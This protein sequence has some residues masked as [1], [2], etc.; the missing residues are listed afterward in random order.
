M[1]QTLLGIL[2][3]F[4]DTPPPYAAVYDL[5]GDGFITILDLLQ[6]LSL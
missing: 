3:Y 1:N 4:G 6:Y 2:Q 5:N